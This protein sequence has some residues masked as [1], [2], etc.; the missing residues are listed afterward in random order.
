MSG[1]QTRV[2]EWMRECFGP[3]IPRDREERNHRFLEESLELVQACGC[4]AS[5]AHRSKTS[6]ATTPTK[7]PSAHRSRNEWAA[8]SASSVSEAGI[9]GNNL[10]LG[11]LLVLFLLR[12]FRSRVP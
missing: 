3:D 9:S 12:L 8:F 10:T 2:D 11:V 1:F 7:K 6:Q 5:E 4:T